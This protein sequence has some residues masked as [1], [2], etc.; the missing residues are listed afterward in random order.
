LF[1]S[2]FWITEWNRLPNLSTYSPA[3]IRPWR[4][5]IGPTKYCTTILLLKPSQNSHCVSLLEPN[6]AFRIV[7]F[8]GCSPNVN[9]SWCREQRDGRLIWPYHARFQL[10]DVQVLCSWHHRLRIW[11]LLSVII[12][13]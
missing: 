8:L 9:S 3:V 11:A 2:N 13:L 5:I 4:V 1:G 12:S 10:S 6:Q 7:G